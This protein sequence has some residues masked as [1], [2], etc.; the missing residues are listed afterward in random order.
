MTKT[1]CAF[2]A[3]ISIISACACNNSASN[4]D[5]AETRDTT[6]APRPVKVPD[7]AVLTDRSHEVLDALDKKD[8]SKFA[9]FIHPEEGVRFS[10]YGYIDTARDKKFTRKQ[11]LDLAANNKSIVWGVHDGSGEPI[12][13][14]LTEYFRRFVYDVKFLEPENLTLNK[15]IASGNSL[16]NLTT[17]YPD[18]Q[19]VESYFSGFDKKYEGMDWRSLRLVFK[20]K[21]D[22][23]YLVG[24]IH[25]Q[26]TV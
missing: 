18:A 17:I 20:K 19:Y 1:I 11:F 25:D 12:N 14:S 5:V 8:F 6:S 24:V 26:W 3:A 10:P 9:E 4:K 7:S 13:L 2:F 16:N 22:T 21:D 23:L 15:T